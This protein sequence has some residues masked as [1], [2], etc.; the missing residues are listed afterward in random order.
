MF[1]KLQWIWLKIS[2]ESQLEI[3]IRLS[4]LP[5]IQENNDKMIRIRQMILGLI[6]RVKEKN[7][8]S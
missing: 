2:T 3:A 6:K 7:K 4:Y 5:T 1:G 8:L